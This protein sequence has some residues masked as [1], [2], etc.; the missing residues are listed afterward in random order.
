[1]AHIFL[2]Y[3]SEDAQRI[4]RLVTALGA[5]NLEVWWD[6]N[7]PAGIDY[8]DFIDGRLREAACVL[9][10]WSKTSVRSRWVQTEASEGDKRG[11]LVP[12]MLDPVTIPLE[13]RRL[14]AANLVGWNGDVE[15][16]EFL[17]LCSAIDRVLN[18][19]SGSSAG[20]EARVRSPMPMPP[21]PRS[22]RWL[23]TG[24][25]VG[26]PLLVLAIVL[27][28]RPTHLV[29][30]VV[31]GV[32]RCRSIVGV[33]EI[34]PADQ[35]IA[36]WWCGLTRDMLNASLNK[37]DNVSVVSK[38]ELDT[39]RDWEKLPE[40]VVARNLGIDRMVSGTI[41]KDGG[42]LI[43]QLQIVEPYSGRMVRSMEIHGSE[44]HLE[45]LQSEAAVQIIK[46]LD[47]PISSEQLQEVL[48][49]QANAGT[50]QYKL[51]ADT[52]GGIE[53]EEPQ[54]KTPSVPGKGSRYRPPDGEGWLSTAY[55][56]D[57]NERSVRDLLETYRKALET[58]DVPR[59][60]EVWVD[61]NKETRDALGQYFSNA[62]DLKVEFRDVNVLLSGDEAL[63]S[64]TRVDD[65]SEVA[66]GRPVHLEIRVSSVVNRIAGAWKIK[67]LKRPS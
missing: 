40:I 60:A 28:S 45:R 16:P 33:M 6:R 36:T 65:F 22:R 11:V 52:M 34:A 63:A 55:A 49:L 57:P 41:Y 53:G 10:I 24:A 1:M 27:A 13:F 8:G 38:Q 46:A 26:V 62:R 51:L 48:A 14:Q 19:G 37:F 18:L 3:A 31:C 43:L 44:G 5:R 21:V 9:V 2:S 30:Q 35:S 39:L 4:H 42:G 50:A 58:K 15:H 32:L 29:R 47:V 61:L 20:P 12:I 67:G 59:I 7:I 25:A 54:P 66:T 56:A 23:F 17:K 64:F